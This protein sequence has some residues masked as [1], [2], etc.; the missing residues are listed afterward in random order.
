M[1]KYV[2]S[3]LG[4]YPYLSVQVRFIFLIIF[5]SYF[6]NL[7]NH[8]TF[9]DLANI[10]IIPLIVSTFGD[11]IICSY[12]KLTSKYTCEELLQ[13]SSRHGKT[14]LNLNDDESK[15]ISF[16]ALIIKL[17]IL[18]FVTTKFKLKFDIK[19]FVGFLYVL[20]YFY[21]YPLDTTYM[22]TDIDYNEHLLNV[23]LCIVACIIFIILIQDN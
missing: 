2:Y 12:F 20:L 21:I 8:K 5:T 9:S 17:M 15:I 1:N 13:L 22:N 19:I 18:I 10:F 6:S 7:I 3:L 4:H 23:Y 14:T 16:L 11:F